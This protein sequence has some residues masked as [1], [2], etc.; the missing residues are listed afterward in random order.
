ME[1]SS[2]FLVEFFKEV[3]PR[4]DKCGKMCRKNLKKCSFDVRHFGLLPGGPGQRQVRL[5]HGPEDRGSRVRLAGGHRRGQAE[6]GHDC[7]RLPNGQRLH[8]QHGQQKSLS[9]PNVF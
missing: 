6:D 1:F 2:E 7:V 8:P 4:T 9:P 3:G 5:V